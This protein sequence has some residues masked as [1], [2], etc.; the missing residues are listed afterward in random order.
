MY[1]RDAETIYTNPYKY[2]ISILQLFIL[3]GLL[4]KHLLFYFINVFIF[5]LH[6]TYLSIY[7]KKNENVNSFR[8]RK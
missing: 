3:H 1:L 8:I 6:I 5:V 2:V 7:L 4:K